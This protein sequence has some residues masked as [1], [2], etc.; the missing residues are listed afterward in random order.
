LP[1]AL[2]TDDLIVELPSTADDIICG[3]GSHENAQILRQL[4]IYAAIGNRDGVESRIRRIPDTIRPSTI[5]DQRSQTAVKITVKQNQS[6]RP[7]RRVREALPAGS[8][9]PT[10]ARSGSRSAPATS[11]VYRRLTLRRSKA[12]QRSFIVIFIM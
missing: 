9:L 6:G 4:A 1:E 12:G 7:S 2:T 8:N 11:I 10:A 5:V 3:R